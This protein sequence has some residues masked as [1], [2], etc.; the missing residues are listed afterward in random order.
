MNIKLNGNMREVSDDC[1]LYD[2][3]NKY[4]ENADV[5]IVN[6]YQTNDNWDIKEGDSITLLKKGMMPSK[7]ELE[8]MM[9]ARHTP[10]VHDKI[11]SAKVAIAGLGGL[12]SNIAIMLARTG[13]GKLLLIDFD[14]V[15]P[16]NLNRQSYY[17][18]HLGIP[19]TEALKQ[20]IEEINPF[21]EIET[22]NCRVEEANITVLFQDYPVVCEAFDNPESKALLVN[23][24]LEKLKNVTVVA[25]SGM[26]GYESANTIKTVRKFNR[27][28]IC[29]DMENEASVG[30]GLMSPRV[31]VCAG[32][33]AN[34]ILR[35]IIGEYEV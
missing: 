22:Q 28:Y 1:N 26:A 31:S 14:I 30:N 13:V 15:E 11:K 7:K 4:L 21:I 17:I 3:K 8:S 6:G 32:H 10:F 29:G 23:G 18:K 16:S 5:M 24:V 33:Q 2:L 19:K 9:M 34:M 35:F 27:L 12:G 20:Q 25:A